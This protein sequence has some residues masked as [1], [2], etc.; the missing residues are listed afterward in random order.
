MAF[1]I[2]NL[3]IWRAGWIRRLITWVLVMASLALLERACA[4]DCIIQIQQSHPPTVAQREIIYEGL[5]SYGHYMVFGG[6]ENG[7]LYAGGVESD[8]ELWP[9]LIHTR[10]DGVMEMLPV[11]LLTQPRQAEIWG[12]TLSKRR[13]LVPG[14]GITPI[15]FPLLWRDDRKIMPYF[16]TKAS[17]LGFTQN[18]L[19]P[20]ATYQN[21]SFHLTSGVKL[22]LECRCDLRVGRL[23]D[24]HFSNAFV[25]RSNPAIALMNV[26]MGIV[27]HL[28]DSRKNH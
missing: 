21:W 26:N 3:R 8:R 9:H 5:V 22:R 7:T 4:E 10:V 2:Q 27:H 16:E 14:A 20:D 11:L 19:S 1:H 25:V 12:D 24:L 13:T 23:S 15:C 18:A 6:A 28:R 17:V